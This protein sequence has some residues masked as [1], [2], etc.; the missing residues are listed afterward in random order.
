[1]SWMQPA[2]ARRIG[3]VLGGEPVPRNQSLDH[4]AAD[5]Q[6]DED[7]ALPPAGTV[8]PH[9][10]GAGRDRTLS[11]QSLIPRQPAHM[12]YKVVGASF[13]ASVF[14][15]NSLYQPI[16]PAIGVWLL[17]GCRTAGQDRHPL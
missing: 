12:Q 8:P 16:I 6:R 13:A 1:M 2:S 9:A 17:W 3:P 10:R 4:L 7:I 15:T 5:G 14:Y 11:G